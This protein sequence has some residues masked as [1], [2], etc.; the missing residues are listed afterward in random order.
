MARGTKSVTVL[1]AGGYGCPGAL[2]PASGSAPPD[3]KAERLRLHTCSGRLGPQLP[4]APPPAPALLWPQRRA[5]AAGEGGLTIT[6]T[7]PGANPGARLPRQANR[8]A[9]PTPRRASVATPRAPGVPRGRRRRRGSPKTA[10]KG[11]REERRPAGKDS[12]A[13]P[14]TVTSPRRATSR[15]RPRSGPASDPPPPPPPAACFERTNGKAGEGAAAGSAP[16]GGGRGRR[17]PRPRDGGG[18]GRRSPVSLFP[19]PPGP[20]GAPD[21]R[22]HL[23]GRGRPPAAARSLSRRGAKPRSPPKGKVA[24]RCHGPSPPVWPAES[25]SLPPRPDPSTA[26]EVWLSGGARFPE[27]NAPRRSGRAGLPFPREGSSWRGGVERRRG[28]QLPAQLWADTG[29][30]L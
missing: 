30:R 11:S 26:P 2:Q 27:T 25:Q 9:S 20:P 23:T 17:S 24:P 15:V 1:G 14:G 19:P 22:A 8:R 18:H 7:A 12:P 21:P 5:E 10:R 29:C 13:G 4:P 6:L 3:S 28:L 16:G